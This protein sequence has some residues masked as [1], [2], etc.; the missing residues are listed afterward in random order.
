VSVSIS[1]VRTL[2]EAV[3]R[4][5]IPAER[6]IAQS[7]LSRSL[8]E[9][10]AARLEVS[11]YDVLQELALDMTGDPALGLHMGDQP[12]VS[13][14]QVVGA[15]VSHCRTIR[16]G[17]DV[18]FRYHRIVADCPAS[19]L[20]P[21]GDEV[22]LVYNFLRTT[23]RCSRLRAEFGIT[24]V[25]RIGQI[26]GGASTTPTEIWFEHEEPTYAAEY[27]RIL[28]AGR[29][30]FSQPST[31]FVMPAAFLDITQLHSSPE[32]F[33]VLK[34]QADKQLSDLDGSMPLSRR[35]HE[36]VVHHFTDVEPDMDTIARR[37]GMSARSLRRRLQDE[38]CSFSEIIGRA[39]GELSCNVLRERNTTI[40]EAAFRLGFSEA[41]SFHRAFKRWTGK[42]PKQFRDEA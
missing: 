12:S 18:F 3:D 39:M 35:I 25:L 4:A 42:T 36:L 27:A 1:L 40:Q 23:P 11:A 6:F 37:M 31:G 34:T 17:L 28:G 22:V 10:A 5:G 38:G 2:I 30:R 33:Q 41:S 29:V 14:F 32:L 19:Y 24:R 26:F 9:D 21:R 7:G 16:E 20:V 13:A 15:L 8:L